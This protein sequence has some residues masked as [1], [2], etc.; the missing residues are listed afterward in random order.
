MNVMNL[1]LL[2]IAATSLAAGKMIFLLLFSPE[3]LLVNA[4]TEKEVSEIMK[5]Y[6][7]PNN[8]EE[9]RGWVCWTKSDKFTEETLNNK[10]NALNIKKLENLKKEFLNFYLQNLSDLIDKSNDYVKNCDVHIRIGKYIVQIM[11]LRLVIQPEIQIAVNKHTQTNH[12]Y[13][14]V[15]GFW[16]TEDAHKVRRFTSSLGRIKDY[17]QG[18]KDPKAMAEAINKIQEKAIE[19]YL[20]AYPE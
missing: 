18:K 6:T 8:Q 3:D 4:A 14:A 1:E 9:I 16:Y 15:K 12:E 13:L 7:F 10:K 2:N 19:A 5:K 20:K 17:E 11:R